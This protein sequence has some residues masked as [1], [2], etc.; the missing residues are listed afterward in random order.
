MLFALYGITSMVDMTAYSLCTKLS[1]YKQ[2][3][4]AIFLYV[5]DS[6]ELP[7]CPRYT[8]GLPDS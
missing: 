3:F 2:C 1:M 7:H 4:L 6:W 8:G 5:C